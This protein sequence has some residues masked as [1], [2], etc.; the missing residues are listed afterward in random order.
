MSNE[1][2]LR[3]DLT[4]FDQKF[5]ELMLNTIPELV[6]EALYE[7]GLQL[8]EDA[9]DRSPQTP[10]KE[11]DLRA[12]RAVDHPIIR[13]DE[14]LVSVGFNMPYAAYQEAGQ[15]EDGT[16]VIKDWT[17]DHVPDPGAHFLESKLVNLAPQRFQ[18]VADYIK[19]HAK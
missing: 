12:S 6:G 10:Y 17:R 11:G 3:V 1:T 9:D 18:R 4:D 7:E 5:T 13:D 2:G 8:L 16:H 19:A 15:R 14:I